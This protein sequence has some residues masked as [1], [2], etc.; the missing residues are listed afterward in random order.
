M[1]S[2]QWQHVQEVRVYDEH[3]L[4]ILWLRKVPDTSTRPQ[5]SPGKDILLSASYQ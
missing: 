3:T 2:L 5:P 4:A 1:S